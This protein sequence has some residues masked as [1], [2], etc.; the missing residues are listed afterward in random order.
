MFGFKLV[1]I[2]TGRKLAEKE[3]LKPESVD[4]LKVLK[5][6][7]YYPF[8][9]FFIFN[10]KDG[11]MRYLKKNDIDLYSFKNKDDQDLEINI[12]A[13][14]GKN[15]SGKSSILELLY[16]AS[17]NL[18]CEFEL[19]K[20]FERQGDPIKDKEGNEIYLGQDVFY[21]KIKLNFSIFYQYN[22]E[23]YKLCFS[24]KKIE[25]F[26]IDKKLSN[27]KTLV[28]NKKNE[29]KRLKDLEKLFYS[30]SVNYSIYGLNS[31]HLG[32]WINPL[33][34]KNDGYRTPLVINPMRT[35]G[36]FDIN[37]ELNFSYDRI[38]T[39]IIAERL[40]NKK[41]GYKI[42][43]TE[44]QNVKSIR[45]TLK[46][47]GDFSFIIHPLAISSN[48]SDELHLIRDVQEVFFG[49]YE[50]IELLQDGVQLPFL[51][52]IYSYISK[53]YKKISSTY[54]E[55]IDIK[56]DGNLSE[57]EKQIKILTKI[58]NDNSHVT[59]KIKQCINFL[60]LNLDIEKRKIWEDTRKLKKQ[61]ISFQF[62]I[63]ELISWMGIHKN[64]SITEFLPPS[65]FTTEILLERDDNVQQNKE[66]T[67]G[68]LSSGEQ[69]YIN[70]I[71]T[72]LY[73]LNNLQSVH[74]SLDDTRIRY[75]SI[76]VIFDEIEL[77]FHP[78]FQKSFISDLLKAIKRLSLKGKDKINSINIL[79]ATHSPFILSDIPSQNILRL[80][81]G[82]VKKY[83]KKEQTFAA[84]IHQLLADNF[85]METLV[86]KFAEEK[87]LDVIKSIKETNQHTDDTAIINL[88]GDSFLKNSLK[89]YKKT[90]NDKN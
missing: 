89:Q 48:S 24:D 68:N 72:V 85:F 39:N 57:T 6:N 69:Q 3:L 44:K 71:Q 18:G 32:D 61:K 55:Y 50:T 49:T 79:F 19:L 15:G 4:Y 90:F 42:K 1:G 27:G 53:K 75:Q 11:T 10:E 28:F 64:E 81:D 86:G 17:Y 88:I 70:S 76:N 26:G 83:E 23:L 43:I 21:N 59:F 47:F 29:L 77:Y 20:M 25:L 9:F 52:E 5:P 22:K 33:F 7:T 34:H 36:N 37:D 30:I 13:I 16:L 35:D 87:I 12:S 73:H 84:N 74:N 82:N 51:K 63:D 2:L 46:E 8:F 40:E 58:K 62:T 56:N 45:F 54:R 80:E 38:L 14:V 31:R 66:L 67:F 60:K 65:I 41:V 78:E